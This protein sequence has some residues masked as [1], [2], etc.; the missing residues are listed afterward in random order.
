MTSWEPGWVVRPGEH[1][2]E[3]M[4]GEGWSPEVLAERCGL[5]VAH[6]ERLLSGEQEITRLIARCL[7]TGTGVS[8][9]TW[10]NLERNYRDGLAA[11]KEEL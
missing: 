3:L 6:I 8:E 10:L 2:A 5:D 7:E 1:V 9:Q 11:G 4:A